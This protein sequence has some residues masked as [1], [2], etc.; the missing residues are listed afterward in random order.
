MSLEKNQHKDEEK[1]KN[2]TG[3]ESK[4]NKSTESELLPRPIAIKQGIIV[5]TPQG[6]NNYPM[7]NSLFNPNQPNNHINNLN[8]INFKK[9]NDIR[10]YNSEES[11]NIPAEKGAFSLYPNYNKINELKNDNMEQ[12]ANHCTCKKTKCVKKYCECYSNGIFC[13]NCKCE[14][15]EN[16]PIFIDNNINKISK[17]EDD[18][19]QNINQNISQNITDNIIELNEMSQKKLIIC[20]C[21][22][23][24]CN[25]NYCE[26]YKAKVKCNNK[27]RCIKCLNKPE[28]IEEPKMKKLVPISTSVSCNKNQFN[29]TTSIKNENNTINN[30]EDNK[31][32]Q[33][34]NTFTIH[35]ISVNISKVRTEINTEKLDQFDSNKFLSKKRN[36]N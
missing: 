17:K 26:C 14:N 31:K 27:C 4:I 6:P 30:T 24:G 33:N 12:N 25:K 2:N 23:S 34:N 8:N 35:R 11:I 3:K 7:I 15:C 16:K 18:I 36:E 22:K 20:T 9:E 5:N 32:N 21:S 1:I 28:E 13:Y 19:N 10:R 29:N